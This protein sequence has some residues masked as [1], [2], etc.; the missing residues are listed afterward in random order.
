MSG[1]EVFALVSGIFQVISFAGQTIELCTAIYNGAS[2]DKRLSL[3]AAAMDSV[4]AEIQKQCQDAPDA[5]SD[6]E[7]ELFALATE[8]R[9]TA[10]DLEEDVNRC[11]G[12]QAKGKLG[13]TFLA[14][15]K[16]QL[17]KPGL[18]KL[19]KEL[20]RQRKTL[21]TKLLARTWSVL[22]QSRSPGF[23]PCR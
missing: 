23:E 3:T 20:E 4:A 7:R 12:S 14:S 15:F 22:L 19:E 21:E 13:A 10:S 9:K 18:K 11:I 16:Y 5:E 8:C 1:A 2:P 17:R 6:A